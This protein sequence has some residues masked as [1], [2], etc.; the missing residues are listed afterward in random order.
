MLHRKSVIPNSNPGR[1]YPTLV[2]WSAG[3]WHE[4]A[5]PWEVWHL[6]PRDS[7][8]SSLPS[9]VSGFINYL[10]ESVTSLPPG[11]MLVAITVSWMH[12]ARRFISMSPSRI[13]GF[14]PRR[15][16]GWTAPILIGPSHVWPLWCCSYRRGTEHGKRQFLEI[17]L[18]VQ[19][20]HRVTRPHCII[21]N[22]S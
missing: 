19:P 11:T 9:G 22:T 20:H 17:G 12:R 8:A 5:K 3:M 18:F 15:Q 7:S 4:K 21:F 1:T 6:L 10:M 2:I 13:R 14:P 16:S